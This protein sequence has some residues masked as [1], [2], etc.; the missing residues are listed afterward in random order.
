M[1]VVTF[2]HI[3]LMIFRDLLEELN[4]IIKEALER[5]PEVRTVQYLE[6]FSY[7]SVVK[8]GWF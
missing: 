4:P 1:C 8:K 6:Y 5:R 7:S 3:T 2:I